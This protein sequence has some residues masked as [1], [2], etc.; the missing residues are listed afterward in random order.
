M[1]TPGTSMGLVVLPGLVASTGVGQD[2]GGQQV[3]TTSA[4]NAA[5][6]HATDLDGD[7][8]ADV[9]SASI[10]D[11]KIAWYE[12]LNTFGS[13]YC[14][15]VM[16]STGAASIISAS[17]FTSIAANSLILSANNLPA[18]IPLFNGYLCVG[19]SGLQRF[20][21]VNVP[22]GGIVTEAVDLSASAA[23]GLDVVAGQPYHFQRW[24]RDPAAGG[25]SANFSNGVEVVFSP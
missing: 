6:V 20:L 22:S 10:F 15:A 23:G 24:N 12:D 13:S 17:G 25:A 18:Q 5:C 4:V 21:A 19:P 11:D 3:I 7:G 1:K 2:F 8:D 9:L 16:N 14:A